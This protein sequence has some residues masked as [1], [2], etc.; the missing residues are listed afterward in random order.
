MYRLFRT[1]AWNDADIE[2]LIN[3]TFA[4][5]LQSLRITFWGTNGVHSES[6]PIF[7]GGKVIALRLLP[8]KPIADLESYTFRSPGGWLRSVARSVLNKY[9]KKAAAES[10]GDKEFRCAAES[11]ACRTVNDKS[12]GLQPSG[13]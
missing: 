6:E 11:P 3:E 7:Q 13:S 12:Q 2:E 4:R 8:A 5:Y 1:R 9:A 10:K